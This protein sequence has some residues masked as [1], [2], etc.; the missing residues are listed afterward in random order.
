MTIK[1]VNDLI[2]N[3]K[4]NNNDRIAYFGPSSRAIPKTVRKTPLYITAFDPASPW[5]CSLTL[6]VSKGKVIMSAIQAA[7]PA[8]SNW[9]VKGTWIGRFLTTGLTADLTAVAGVGL[10]GEVVVTTIIF[11]L[12]IF[13]HSFICVYYN[14]LDATGLTVVHSNDWLLFLYCL[15]YLIWCFV[16]FESAIVFIVCRKSNT[17]WNTSVTNNKLTSPIIVISMYAKENMEPKMWNYVYGDLR[18]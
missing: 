9:T 5:T 7:V 4:N 13:Y 1:Y 18:I 14:L 6:T 10:V 11:C 8:V 12:Y 16:L 17:A 15:L 2:K 3:G